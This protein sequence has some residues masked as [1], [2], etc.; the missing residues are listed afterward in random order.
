MSGARDHT[1]VLNDVDLELDLDFADHVRR[2]AGLL[3]FEV[4]CMYLYDGGP[5]SAREQEVHGVARGP[6]PS[7]ILVLAGRMG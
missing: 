4:E 7:A 5:I 3:P 1:C 6:R 2:S